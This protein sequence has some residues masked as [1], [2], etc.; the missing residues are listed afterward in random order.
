MCPCSGN[1]PWGQRGWRG[2]P[3]GL[4]SPRPSPTPPKALGPPSCLCYLELELQLSMQ[5]VLLTLDG[6]PA[7]QLH[8]HRAVEDACN[9]ATA[10]GL[11]AAPGPAEP[12]GLGGVPAALRRE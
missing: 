10:A 7:A 2:T 6:H 3:Q 1:H 11:R 5:A 4:A 12:P 9:T 8:G